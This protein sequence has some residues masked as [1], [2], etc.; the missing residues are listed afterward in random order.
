MVEPSINLKMFISSEPAKIL[1]T[2]KASVGA[3]RKAKIA[4]APCHPLFLW[5]LYVFHPIVKRICTNNTPYALSIET[6]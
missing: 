1:V 4:Q 6:Y 3:S 5:Y 2:V